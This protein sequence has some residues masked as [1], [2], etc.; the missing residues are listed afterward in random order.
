MAW[1]SVGTHHSV[2]NT[3]NNQASTILSPANAA[4]IGAVLVLVVAVDNNQ[5]TDGDE[6]AVSGVVDSAGGN[7]WIKAAEHCNGQGTAQ[8]GTTCSVWYCQLATAHSVATT[9]TVSFTNSASRDESAYSIWEFAV[10]AGNTVSV[11][12]TNVVAD[13]GIDPSSLDATTANAEFLRF[14]GIA[15]ELNSAT[16]LTATDG[17]WTVITTNRSANTATAQSVRGEFKISTGTGASSDPTIASADHASVYVAF[18]EVPGTQALTAPL[19]D[20]GTDTF[21]APT[22][23]HVLT[24]SLFD[25]GTDTFYTHEITQGGP[26]QNLTQDSSFDDGT[27]TFYDPTVTQSQPLVASLYADDDTFY[28]HALGV[29]AVNLAPSLYVDDDTF[30]SPTVAPVAWPLTAP[31]YA[32]DDTF[33]SPTV[34]AAYALTP[35]LYSDDDTFHNATVSAGAVTLAPSLFADDDTFYSPTVAVGAVDLAPSLYADDDTFFAHAITT[36]EGNLVAELYVDDDTFYSATITVGAVGLVAS[37]YADDDTFYS[38]TV[39][40][41]NALT[42]SLYA[43]DD[44]FYSATVSAGAVDLAPSLYADDDTFYS[45]SVAQG[46]ALIPSLYVDDDTFYSATV[47]PGAVDLAPSL[48]ADD[49]TFFSH[50]ISGSFVQE[51]TPSLFANDNTFFTPL[52]FIPYGNVVRVAE[53]DRIAYSSAEERVVYAL[54]Q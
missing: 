42:P 33:F 49:D 54:E 40:S 46:D 45:S 51:L 6:G 27:D 47:T 1:S 17:T 2:G 24:A 3:A 23:S 15:S 39:A 43:D 12:A 53:E 10:G 20:D 9:I 18:K 36:G 34:A 52:V 44:T 4:A 13:D 7:T 8:T 11:E 32:D 14:R 37:L 41:L 38:A 30:Y 28:T 26:A 5:T 29:G 22:V 19:F 21:F 50:A 31:L 48:Y 16:A 35:S 25:D